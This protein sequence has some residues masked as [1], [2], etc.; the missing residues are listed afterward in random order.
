MSVSYANRLPTASSSSQTLPS[1]RE[2]LPPHLH[3]EIESSSYLTSLRN[4]PH[5][6]GLSAG[7][8]RL[9][10]ET[11]RLP[12]APSPKPSFPPLPPAY[13]AAPSRVEQSQL[14]DHGSLQPQQQQ[15]VSS[16]RQRQILPP[17]RDI[18][19][20]SSMGTP[21]GHPFPE[22][23]RTISSRPDSFSSQ[24]FPPATYVDVPR[25]FSTTSQT[26]LSS[27][28]GRNADP[29]A[30]GDSGS[31]FLHGQAPYAYIPAIHHG[32]LE[33][34]SRQI[35]LHH[36][37]PNFGVIGDAT[38]P[39]IKRRRGNLPKPVTD[40]LRAWFHEHLDHPYPSEEDKQMF[41]TRTGLSISQISNWFI[42]ARRR[43][44][45]A[46]RNQMRSS[47]SDRDGRR[48]SPSSDAEIASQDSISSPNRS[49]DSYRS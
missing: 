39:K 46:L 38:D 33:S 32:D 27:S 11:G 35:P 9:H 34:P 2:L 7:D 26:G 23:R 36:Q 12:Y 31:P 18:H 20:E 21:A 42:N 44:L 6:R 24:D 45:P 41:M 1:F 48:Q 16:H 5:E 14:R 3:E 28:D 40:I 25:A 8:H 37:Q 13:S 15:Y 29:Y 22:S 43:Q 47:G 10:T 30:P 19:P 4:R 49:M 17:I